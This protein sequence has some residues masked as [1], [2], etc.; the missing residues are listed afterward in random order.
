MK[1]SQDRDVY[2]IRN[3]KF[4]LF[5]LRGLRSQYTLIPF[6]DV[7]LLEIFLYTTKCHKK[8]FFFTE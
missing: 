1:I 6:K 5:Y 4:R 8:R 2:V 7:V 3:L